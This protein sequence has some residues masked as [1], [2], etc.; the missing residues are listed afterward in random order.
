M[1][2]IRIAKSHSKAP[3]RANGKSQDNGPRCFRSLL[4]RANASFESR[5]RRLFQIRARRQSTAVIA[6]KKKFVRSRKNRATTAWP[7]LR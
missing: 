4:L 3:S 7:T 2:S 1:S 5:L 6:V